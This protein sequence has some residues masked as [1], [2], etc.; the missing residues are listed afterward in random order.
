[1]SVSFSY[2]SIGSDVL[3]YLPSSSL[4][5]PIEIASIQDSLFF[6]FFWA[7]SAEALA[8]PADLAAGGCLAD[9]AEAG[10]PVESWPD[11]EDIGLPDAED[12]GLPEGCAMTKSAAPRDSVEVC[13]PF[14]SLD[15]PFCPP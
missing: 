9:E 15:P 7:A 13:E 14:L 10:L 6:F 12:M 2:K 3:E 8:A 1:M 11:A 5:D 4:S